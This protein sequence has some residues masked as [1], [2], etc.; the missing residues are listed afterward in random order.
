MKKT[1]LLSLLLTT[2]S[3]L[4]AAQSGEQLLD[5][6]CTAC[7][8]TSS[9]SAKLTNGKMG[10]PPMWGVM[11]KIKNSFK[12]KE[13]GATF[14]VNYTMY[15]STEKMLFPAATKDYFGLMPSLQGEV[16]KE[17]LQIIAEYL[18]QSYGTN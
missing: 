5:K 12:T 7:H 14:I 1:L 8:M 18:Y 16:T 9:S 13:E 3:L 15:P 2:S 4:S 6:K 11:K 10:G 17:E